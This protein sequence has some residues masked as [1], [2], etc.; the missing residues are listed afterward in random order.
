MKR[1]AP[2]ILVVFL[3][4][5][6]LASWYWPFGGKKKEAPRMASLLEPASTL[7][8]S[9]SDLAQDGKYG[10]AIGEYNKAL[11]ELERIELENPDRVESPEFATVRNKRAIITAYI[12][13]LLMEQ[14]KKNSRAVTVTDTTE[15]EKRYAAEKQAKAAARAETPALAAW[16]RRLAAARRQFDEKDLDG[17]AKAVAA[18]LAERPNAAGALNLRAA[19][20]MSRG[21]MKAAEATLYQTTVSN[22]DSPHAYYNLARLVLRTRGAEGVETARRYYET[23]RAVGGAVDAKLEAQ[24]K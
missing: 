11:A 2:T 19:I 3:A 20:E 14:V 18:L 13:S 15:L 7:M 16:R 4:A 21:D 5:N 12:D 9:A 1:I 24:L 17:A 22:P 23:G 8:D 10:E 6:A